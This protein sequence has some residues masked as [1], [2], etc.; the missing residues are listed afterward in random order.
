MRDFPIFTTEYGVSTLVLREIPYRKEAYIHI[1]G[2]QEGNEAAHL[3]ECAAFCRMAGADRV[4]AA[5]EGLGEY[6]V[7]T[8]VLQMHGPVSADPENLAN[9]FPVTESTVSKWREIHNR[10]MAGVDNA[11][12]LEKRDEEKILKSGSAY[13]VHEAGALLGIG[14]VEDG[15]LLAVAATKSGAGER[16]MHTLMSLIEEDTMTLEVAST[17]HRAIRLYERL[18]FVVTGE[19]IRWHDVTGVLER[20][21]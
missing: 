14:W 13:F 18:G 2:V 19:R 8:S 3:R 17:N 4:L 1:R 16:I 20:I 21:L 6:P 9:L 10:A 11:G 5:G 7:Y 12:T 15:T